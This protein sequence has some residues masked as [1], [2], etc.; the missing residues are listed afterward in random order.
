M[1]AVT[2]PQPAIDGAISD[3][4][5]DPVG[6][7]SAAPGVATAGEA[8][9][10]PRR[11]RPRSADVDQRVLDA[12]LALASEVG[13]NGMSMDDVAQR[14]GASKA[15]IYRRWPSKEAMVLDAM[16]HAMHP[17][18]DVDT[19]SLRGDLDEYLIE[20]A[21]RMAQGR[22]TELLPHLI[23]VAMRDE[24]LRDSL[25]EYVQYRRRPLRA[26][27]DRAIERGELAVD[28]DVEI[29]LDALIGPFIYRRLLSH[30]PLDAAFVAGLLARVFPQ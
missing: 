28:T 19:G 23:E 13:I 15:T 14:A 26:I 4:V 5:G 25:D 21:G 11:G 18:D 1:T 12:T 6:E 7:V 9:C 2:V 24:S 16:R 17:V 29:L 3:P 10:A 20:L 8:A 30:A 22:A 27:L